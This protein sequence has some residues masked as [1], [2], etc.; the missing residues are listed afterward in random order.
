MTTFK[1]Q[2]KEMMQSVRDLDMDMQTSDI[3]EL[4][5]QEQE[6]YINHLKRTKLILQDI[7]NQFKNI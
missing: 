1:K 2:L 5:E 7:I 3:T 6:Y 4:T